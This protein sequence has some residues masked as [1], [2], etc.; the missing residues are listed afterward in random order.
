MRS[1][2]AS[3]RGVHTRRHLMRNLEV[4]RLCTLASFILCKALNSNGMDD[5]ELANPAGPNVFDAAPAPGFVTELD[6]VSVTFSEAVTG[7]RAGDFLLN[8]VPAE[9]VTGGP[10]VFQFTFPQPPYGPVD[11]SWGTLHS[12]ASA[13]DASRRFDGGQPGSTWAYQLIDTNGPSLT[14][15][16]PIPGM[17]LVRLSEVEVNFSRPVS[18]VDAADL[19]LNGVGATNITG[20]GAGPYL[21]TFRAAQ[22]GT[23]T[24][25]WAPNHGIATDEGMPIGFSGSSWSYTVN[26]SLPKPLIV[27]NELLTENQTGIVD[28]D[29]DPE[30]WIELFNAGSTAVDLGGWSLSVDREEE[31][32]WVFPPTTLPAKGFLIVW[33]SGKDRRDL[34]SDR[35]YHTNFKLNASGD[36]LRLFGPELPRALMNE[37]KYPEQSSD[38]SYGRQGTG[39]QAE[40]KY[41]AQ[42]T[43]GAANSSSAITGRVDEVHF[44]V[45]RGFFNA[46][47]AL[48]LACST[49]GA[50]VRYTLNG[51]APSP[52]NGFYY[53]E[54]I[55][56]TNT[57]VV[58]ALALAPN[59]LPSRVRSHSY[60]MNLPNN[61]R[62][63]PVLSL[64][65]GTNNLYGR[66]GI[67]E[68]N[69]RNTTKHGPGWE[70]PVSV[71]WIRPEDNGGFQ[72]DAGLRVAGGDYIRG[73]YNYRSSTPPEGKYSFR[74]YFRG[75]YGPGRLNYRLFPESTV[76]SFNTL[77]LRAGMND[78][79]NPF[80]KDEFVRELSTDVG[81]PACHG[82]FVYLF[83]NG[84][85]KGLYNPCERVDDDFL[86]AYR[87]GGELWDVIGPGNAAVRGDTAAWTQLRTAARKDLNV[88]SN[89]VDVAQRMD[90]ANFIDYLLPLIWADNDDWPHNNTRAAREKVAGA[91]FR[92]Y[93]WDAEF[94]F[95]SHSVTYDTIATTL[96]TLSPPW[97]TS[98][99][100]AMF[101]SLKKTAE[102][103]LLFADRIHRAFFND[104]PLTDDQVRLRYSKVKAQAAPSISG[105]N[106]MI[107]S[108]INN[109]RRYVM[110]AFQKA[111][112]LASTNAP[113][114]SQ[115]GGHV[116]PGYA[117][118][119]TNLRGDILFTTDGS[120]PRVPFANVPRQ[121][122]QKYSR[123]IP[124]TAPLHLKARSLEGTNW[125]ALLDVIYELNQTGRQI[126]I[127]EVMYHPSGGDAFEYIEL[128]NTGKL[129]EDLSGCSF[130]GV[131]FR[132]PTP[133][134]PL[135]P[136]G[137]I[138]LANGSNQA[139]FHQRYPQVQVA[140]WF[141]GSLDNG[142]ERLELFD[143][144]GQSITLL[145]YQDQFPWPV[146]AD[147]QGASLELIDPSGDPVAPANWQDSLPGGSPG[148][149]NQAAS[150]APIRINELQAGSGGDWLELLNPGSAI[151]SIGGWSLSDNS[152]PRRFVF[153]TGTSIPPG[154]YLKVN[155]VE[156]GQ[157][158]LTAPFQLNRNGETIA[159]YNTSTDRVDAVTFG[160]GID[161][162]TIGLI[163]GRWTLCEPTPFT[164]NRP[165]AL[166][167]VRS[168][169]VNEYLANSDGSEDWIELFN[170]G[171]LPVALQ[172][173]AVAT[174][175]GA[176]RLFAPAFIAS[177]GFVVLYA[178]GKAGPGHLNV[179]LPAAGDW[180]A[181][182]DSD[183]T[184]IV[185][186]NY[187]LQE[188]NVS[189][190]R[191]PDGYG[192]FQPLPYSASPGRSNVEP[193]AGL[194]LRLSEIMAWPASGPGW[195]EIE[196]ASEER[197]P[198]AGYWLGLKAPDQPL[199]S[200]PLP[201][202]ET[203]NPGQRKLFYFAADRNGLPNNPRIFSAP[204]PI[205]GAVLTLN[206][207]AG[208]ILDR[209]EYGLQLKGRS[210]GRVGPS[211][212]LL[213]APTPEIAN[214]LPAVLDA[215]RQL[216][217]N[218][219]LAAG[220][221]TNDF[222]ELYNGG[223]WPV[224]LENWV[225]TDDPSIQGSTNSPFA[226]LSFIGAGGFVQFQTDRDAQAGPRHTAFAL[227][228]LGET[229]RLLNPAHEVID[230]VDFLMQNE[231]VSEGRYPD[232]GLGIIGF[233]G[234][235]TPGSPN[236]LL[237]QDSDHD[238]MEDGW[239]LIHQLNPKS[240]NDASEDA[241]GD[242]MSNLHEFQA[243]TDPTNSRSRLNLEVSATERDQIG[244]RFEAQSGRSYT[245]EFADDLTSEKWTVLREIPAGAG[246]REINEHDSAPPSG[247]A[248]RFYRL[249]VQ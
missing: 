92:F 86:Q 7:V 165:A 151:V 164:A 29:G 63:L 77:H 42:A 87:G 31:G 185:R 217:L 37:V 16:L 24:I 115:F 45:E 46:P 114:P 101:N 181:L 107:S 212:F 62:L 240:A 177:H 56:V 133:F 5:N 147:G 158:G 223:P 173:C 204:L 79:T 36:T 242:G 64:V 69:P 51:S 237:A 103:K 85:Y 205:D 157:G 57:T 78:P 209:V 93:P 207:P 134:P 33:A 163:N 80:I 201:A 148:R 117:L 128:Q 190:G 61:R 100:Q 198:L 94:A 73:R 66:T 154:G 82:T 65:T 91:P 197:V 127:T 230:S 161:S 208:R 32:Q 170:T 172:G 146:R 88:S 169:T 89:Y 162:N 52:T 43:P 106:D 50:R 41:M 180:F 68:F 124:I 243:G 14:K 20:A 22:A 140:G 105:F 121:S 210:I 145:E 1:F 159:L 18:G 15:I 248:A 227:D 81:I 112:F 131:T 193:P 113:S 98:D 34:T 120:D 109:R 221:G 30:D 84:V 19:Q 23:A 226:A 27:I 225:L 111:G 137:R 4:F 215:G 218:E 216:R 28:E 38:Y 152:D 55:G 167:Q 149:A 183:G 171:T 13:S 176:A 236:A 196:N 2:D 186:V 239:E 174:T 195:V 178:D 245:V 118:S 76:Q 213:A 71:E 35:K 126:A 141:G 224:S 95:S 231:G 123:A 49:P 3:A 6:S 90:L 155:C 53:V 166:G 59:Q 194:P 214:G 138:V 25:R 58:R 9:A 102:F 83:L 189:T 125:S 75:E 17:K 202:N 188:P 219:W 60:L 187:R 199:V 191:I 168:V 150:P 175:N 144:S 184:E 130:G 104:G 192:P 241:D 139:D 249:R 153:P 136:G 116:A 96:S 135:A 200:D 119:L 74:V 206:N 39:T 246:M 143:A 10:T 54:P 182:L 142:G 11:I 228:R 99:Y 235:A 232:G 72:I 229:I 203:L 234:S 238:R 67:M 70:R 211:W 44:S 97:G 132:F 40:W 222:V 122:A 220:G 48:S 247:R 12:I 8:G 110:N 47:F 26:P 244:L 129:P 233:P 160:P 156:K 108:W 21:F 179:K